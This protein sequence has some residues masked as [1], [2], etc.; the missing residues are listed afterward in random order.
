MSAGIKELLALEQLD[1]NLYR[2]THHMENFRQTLF[3][4][5]VLAQGLKAAFLTV[6]KRLPHSLH[7]YFLHAGTSKRAVIY[8]VEEIKNGRSISNRRVN[9]RQNGKIIFTMTVS[10]HIPE[11]GYAHQA[12]FPSNVPKPNQVKTSDKQKLYH[13]ADD[14]IQGS[15][16]QGPFEILPTSSENFTQEASLPPKSQFWIRATETLQN[17]PITQLCTLAFAT[18][19]GLLATTLMPHPTTLFTHDILGASIDH[20]LWFHDANINLNEWVLCDINS[21]WSGGA[22]GFAQ[23]SIYSQKGA[24][25]GSTTQEGLIRPLKGIST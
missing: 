5:Q 13:L 19:F 7:A 1:L 3:G 21:P 8:D 10:F 12:P 9:A 6:D 20:A 11:S 18:D 25:L 4:G 15:V 14:H 2:S 22:R 23:G 24:L 16:Q 17:D